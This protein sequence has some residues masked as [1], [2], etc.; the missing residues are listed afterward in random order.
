M[1]EQGCADRD[2]DL[3]FPNEAD[4][5]GRMVAKSICRHACDFR[6]VCLEMAMAHEGEKPKGSRHG[7]WG[8]LDEGQR[9]AL[10]RRLANARRKAA[11]A[12]ATAAT[13]A[14]G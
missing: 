13:E 5:V 7:V 12:D 14:T 1:A 9:A 10:A 6:Q 11:A 3:W 4:E 2:P 8:G